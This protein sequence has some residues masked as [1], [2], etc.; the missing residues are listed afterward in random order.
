MPSS[1]SSRMLPP[2]SLMIIR[3]VPGW[4]PNENGL[5]KPTAQ[6]ARFAPEVVPV[7]VGKEVGLSEGIV[8]SLLIRS[9]LPRRLVINCELAL[10]AFSPTATYSL[11]SGPKYMAPPLWLVAVLRL[12]RSSTL[13]AEPATATSPLAV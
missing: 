8:P 13:N 10:F 4:N 12:S 9:I 5:R 2:T 1:I 11:P 7:M 6:M 3:P